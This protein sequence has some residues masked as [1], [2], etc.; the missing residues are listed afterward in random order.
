LKVLILILAIV[1][2]A[3][4]NILIKA[5]SLG[6]N[7]TTAGGM[8]RQLLNPFFMGGIFCFGLALIAYRH[9]LGQGMK[10]SVAYPMMTTSGFAIVLFASWFF[11]KESLDWVQ[12]TGIGLLVLGLW[13]IASRMS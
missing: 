5:S 7:Q 1:L 8:I 3:S 12:W 2:N 9:V 4:A 11:F 10:L 6:G 13:L